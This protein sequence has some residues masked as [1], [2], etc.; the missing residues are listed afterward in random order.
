[1]FIRYFSIYFIFLV[2]FMVYFIKEDIEEIVEEWLEL[3]AQGY[4]NDVDL[5]EISLD[6]L[7]I[8]RSKALVLNKAKPS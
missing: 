8:K 6:S 2:K 1:M 4:L 3:C 5:K 7:F